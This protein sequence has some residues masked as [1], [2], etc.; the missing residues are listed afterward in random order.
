MCQV[1]EG[2]QQAQL[3]QPD[4]LDL[5]LQL[6]PDGLGRPAQHQPRPDH[7]VEALRWLLEGPERLAVEGV[8][9][10]QQRQVGRHGGVLEQDQHV[11]EGRLGVGHRLTVGRCHVHVAHQHEVTGADGLPRPCARLQ[12]DILLLPHHLGRQE[13]RG[14]PEAV[15]CSPLDRRRAL[16]SHPHRWVGALEGP[17]VD[18]RLADRVI[19]PAM[20]EPRLRPRLQ[21]H[22]DALLEARAQLV[23]VH[24]ELHDLLEI[25]PATHAELQ[26]TTRQHVE[27]RALLGQAHRLMERHD[28]DH[29]SEADRVGASG[30]RG[31][32]HV[33]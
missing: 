17:R 33:R 28:V 3:P 18:R 20:R 12:V 8:A 13:D 23:E 19:R 6:A 24:A 11:R 21:D 22:V 7:V 4:R 2:E 30:Q 10:G 9:V 25:D 5:H 14:H 27:H 26:S 16:R 1:P 31:E 29:R 32:H 15:S